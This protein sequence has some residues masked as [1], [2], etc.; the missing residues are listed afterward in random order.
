MSEET[1]IWYYEA[2]FEVSSRILSDLGF[3]E[4]LVVY[5]LFILFGQMA[6]Q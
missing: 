5:S 2:D 3:A 4:V 6:V 1:T